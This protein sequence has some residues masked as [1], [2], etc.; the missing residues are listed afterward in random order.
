MLD[1]TEDECYSNVKKLDKEGGAMNIKTI[2]LSKNLTQKQ[3]ATKLNVKRT[4]VTM[5]E[6]GKSMPNVNMLKKIANALDCTIDDLVKE[7]KQS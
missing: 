1:K 6:N 4:T 5:W 2:R 3:L 7:N